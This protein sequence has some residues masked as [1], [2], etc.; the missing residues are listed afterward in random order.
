MGKSAREAAESISEKSQKI[1]KSS[2]FQTLSQTAEA[3]RKELDESA[4]GARVY[5][6]PL[7]LRKRVELPNYEDGCESITPNTE[8]TGVELHKDSR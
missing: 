6:P 5:Q 7:K 4:I 8:A 1:G 2:A 3:V